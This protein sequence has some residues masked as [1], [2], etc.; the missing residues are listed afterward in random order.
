VG[1]DKKCYSSCPIE[2]NKKYH[3]YNDN[4]CIESC[5]ST[6]NSNKCHK[7]G[8]TVC[9]PS[10]NDIPAGPNGKYLF[11][12][13]GQTAGEKICSDVIPLNC[14]LYEI[15]GGVK[16]CIDT[17]TKKFV[18]DKECLAQCEGYKA[19]YIDSNNGNICL[20]SLNECFS[21]NYIYYNT[22]SNKCWNEL[23]T[24]YI[25]KSEN[26][27]KYEVIQGCGDD[28]LEHEG[29]TPLKCI[30]FEKC[31][32]LG[33]FKKGIKCVTNCDS[34]DYK[35]DQECISSCNTGTGHDYY[36]HDTKD[37]IPNCSGA[38]LYHKEND[39]ECFTSCNEIDTSG[40]YNNL[41]GNVCSSYSCTYYHTIE[42]NVKKCYENIQ[43]C[44][45]AGY[46]YLKENTNECISESECTDFKVKEIQN[47]NGEIVELG[48]CFSDAESCK[49]I[50]Y[51][52]YNLNLK[53]CWKDSCKDGLLTIILDIDGQP[54][55]K[56]HEYAD[57]SKE[58]CVSSCPEGHFPSGNYCKKKMFN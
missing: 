32:E 29:T 7:D 21:N 4:I 51:N 16:K 11:E 43:E 53:E 56:E 35:Y 30:S 49:A 38:H 57:H 18:K 50:G 24:G 52:F 9:Y 13:D 15:V 22:N 26:D 5:A 20:T 36:K 6:G 33:K 42:N 48:K 54:N 3:N 46:S 17:C 47:A 58:N 23:P 8:D 28:L 41:R 10:C 55:I 37:C 12:M 34:T 19:N 27:G 44:V 40:T 45:Q 2:Q 1:S 31:K 14:L 25:I 39:Y